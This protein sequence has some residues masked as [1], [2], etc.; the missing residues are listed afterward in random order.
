V[1]LKKRKQRFARPLL[2]HP[3]LVEHMER[4]GLSMFAGALALGLEGIVVNDAKSR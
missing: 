3:R 2:G 1:P 4:E